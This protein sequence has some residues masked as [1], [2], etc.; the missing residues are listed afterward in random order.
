MSYKEDELQQ[1]EEMGELFFSAA[2][3]AIIL[4]IDPDKFISEIRM[5]NTEAYKRYKKGWLTSEIKL[6]KS[7][8]ESAENGS[9]PAQ[10]LMF[11]IN[12]R[13]NHA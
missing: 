1:I 11:E 8:M 6:R 2:D 3:I 10:Q 7:I 13:N 12:K 9:N 4:E 5:E